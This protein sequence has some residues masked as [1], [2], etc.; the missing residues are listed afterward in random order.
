MRYLAHRRT[1]AGIQ[2][3]VLV[4]A[5]D[6]DPRSSIGVF[7]GDMRILVRLRIFNRP[8]PRIGPA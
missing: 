6:T 8:R 3:D 2:F 4:G 1:S 7:D 5:S